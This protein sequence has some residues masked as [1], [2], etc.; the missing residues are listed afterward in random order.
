MSGLPLRVRLTLVFALV[1]SLVLT[2]TGVFL[3]ARLRDSLDESVDA[4]LRARA[5]DVSTLVRRGGSGLGEDGAGRLAETDESFA[6]VLRAGDGTV[7]DATPSLTQSLLTPEELHD[8]RNGT[9]V[10]DRGSVPGLDEARVRLLA[11]PANGRDGAVV[12]VAGASLDDRD[13]ALEALRTQLF[14][15]GPLALLLASLAGYALA[16]AVLR[17]IEAMRLRAAQVSAVNAAERLPVPPGDDE[18]AR[19]ARTLNEM[20]DRLEAG[21]ERE[22]RFVAD[23]SHELR[24]PL[25]LLTT[26]L[27][28]ALRRPRSP[29][30]LRA[31]LASAAEETDRLVLLADD[32]LVLSR[33][34]EGALALHAE[35]VAARELLDSVARRFAARAHDAGR[36]VEVDAPEGITI[37]GDRLRLEQALGNLADN[38]LR[39]GGGPVLLQARQRGDGVELRVSDRGRGF[40]DDFLPH[41]FERFSRADDSR[42]RGAVGL[43]LS[44]VEA[45]VRA[46]GGRVSAA[47]RAGGGA[48]VALLLPA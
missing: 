21:L 46:H 41:A 16:G 1:M 18:V 3:H 23:A 15:G 25:S 29:D 45:I 43:G 19:L 37:T 14:I 26:E 36:P 9:L 44:L 48:E 2:A 34:D 8:A 10:V 17:P 13:E 31:A 32:L 33:A 42:I 27:E 6:Q 40:P 5:D 28:L 30:E 24:T 22:R 35:P 4:S 39:Y 47:N 20:L 11:T 7:V 12:V 38:A